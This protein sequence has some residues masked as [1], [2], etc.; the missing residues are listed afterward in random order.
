[1]STATDIDIREIVGST[2]DIICDWEDQE[3]EW[4]CNRVATWWLII[5]DCTCPLN[6]GFACS[7]CAYQLKTGEFYCTD[8]GNDIDNVTARPL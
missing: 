6:T 7:S 2:E 8:C 4:E 5:H 3:K 1:M